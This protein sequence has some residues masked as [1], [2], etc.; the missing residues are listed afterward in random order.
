MSGEGHSDC[1]AEA[2]WNRGRGEVK[3]SRS[4]R[5]KGARISEEKEVKGVDRRKNQVF[6]D[7]KGTLCL[8]GRE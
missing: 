7:Y 5:E 8:E 3:A 2:D 1:C 6:V 4:I